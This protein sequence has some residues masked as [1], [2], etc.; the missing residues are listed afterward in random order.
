MTAAGRAFEGRVALVTGGG[1]GIGAATA[2]AFARAGA[3]VV[4]SD[5]DKERGEAVAAEINGAGGAAE[6]VACVPV[7]AGD[8]I[9]ATLSVLGSVDVSFTHREQNE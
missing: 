5:L 7:S 8:H 6:F 4:V 3:S 1:S 9:S 2:R